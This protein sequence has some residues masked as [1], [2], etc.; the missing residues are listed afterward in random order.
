[1]EEGVDRVLI[2]VIAC[3]AKLHAAHCVTIKVCVA[4]KLA[5]ITIGCDRLSPVFLLSSALVGW[6]NR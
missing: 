1:M 4:L 5:R 6:I 2:G 3:L